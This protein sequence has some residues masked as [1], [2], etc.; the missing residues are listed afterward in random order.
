[1]KE[2]RSGSG[3]AYPFNQTNVNGTLYFSANDGTNGSELW[4]SDGT[5]AGTV[6]VS[7][8]AAGATG[9]R[10]FYFEN[11]NG[12]L[13][14]SAD[15][16]V[17]G[18]ELWK[19]DG[20]AAGT[21]LVKNINAGTESSDPQNLKNVNGVL[22][23][24]ADD[25]THGQELWKSNGTAAGTTLVKDVN[26]GTPG[27]DPELHFTGGKL[28]FSASDGTGRQMWVTS[29]LAS[30]TEKLPAA[31]GQ[32]AGFNPEAIQEVK[33]A[34]YF[35]ATS[36]NHGSE[37][38]KINVP[39]EISGTSGA[40]SLIVTFTST[41]VSVKR[42]IDGGSYVSLGSSPISTT[43]SLT[44]LSASDK[45]RIVGTSGNDS[46]RISNAGYNVNTGLLLV[47]GPASLTIAGVA[48][49][50]TYKIDS[51]SVLGTLRLD[52]AGVGVD[53]LDFSLTTTQAVT[54]NMS[55][56]L[57][58]VVNANLT[59]LLGSGTT[60]ENAVGGSKG[61]ILIG[62][63]LN[64]SLKG[65]NGNDVLVGSSGNDQ[66]FGGAGFDIL[67]GGLGLDVLDGA[68]DDDILIAGRTNSDGNI[69]RLADLRTE[70]QSAS[71]RSYATRV[72]NLRVG[73]GASGASLKK[74]LTVVNDGGEDDSLTGGGGID[75]YFSA[76]DDVLA[77]ISSG[78][79]ELN[80]AL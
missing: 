46:I 48:G 40:D 3:S 28:Y 32:P 73:V 70:W 78:S 7:N 72:A 76:P 1:V 5:D 37:L 34:V 44:N 66:L 61:D 42:S 21:V 50:D 69:S 22:Y 10:P 54:L 60:F 63:A 45:V 64:N 19:S 62:N 35:A 4:K 18:R 58:Q 39:R 20:T 33:G 26:V 65:G 71:I 23:F 74:R 80:D 51:D 30:N 55:S 8:I 36:L 6:L 57:S 43:L 24:T 38:F 11:V 79:G 9:G 41:A 13:Y 27:S 17:N 77:D 12:T 53:T 59:L 56:T 16:G 29:G 67:I 14:F 68:G 75:W 49:N 47:S 52:E 2:I 25:G 15:D 31:S